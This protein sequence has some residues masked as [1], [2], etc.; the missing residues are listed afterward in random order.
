MCELRRHLAIRVHCDLEK[1]LR[2]QNRARTLANHSV[3]SC[4]GTCERKL[5]VRIERRLTP[6]DETVHVTGSEV[7]ALNSLPVGM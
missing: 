6:S 4:H 5:A 7:G 1:N 2:D 3:V